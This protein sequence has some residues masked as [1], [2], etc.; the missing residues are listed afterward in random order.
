MIKVPFSVL[1]IS[2]LRVIGKRFLSVSEFLKQFFP[3]LE[4]EL[5]QSEQEVNV[6]D[7]IS[8]CIAATLIFFLFITIIL[9]V[10]FIKVGHLYLGI[11]I[12]LILSFFVFLQ[13]LKYPKLIAR[14]KSKDIE[15]N[16]LPAL[17]TIYIQLNS[18]VNLFD[19]FISISNSNYGELSKL[20]G[21]VVKKMNAGAS[22][23]DVLEELE[24]NSSSVYLRKVMWQLINGMK[25]G[26]NITTV[27]NEIIKSLSQEQLIQ[28]EAYGS[29]LNPLAMFYMLLAV[30]APALGITFLVVIS[31]FVSLNEYLNKIFLIVLFIFV[32]LFQISFLGLIKTKRPALLGD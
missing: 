31:S 12:A 22:Q 18:G 24:K 6:K 13:Q 8:M 23:I 2:P 30:I 32:L 20:F 10:I 21:K 27:L 11:I 1:P 9:S 26:S 28:I 15:R 7:Y 25:S 14:K 17:R 29:Q 4:N 19:I 3:F 16:L 5:K